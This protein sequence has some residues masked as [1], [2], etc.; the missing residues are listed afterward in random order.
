MSRLQHMWDRGTTDCFSILHAIS[1][2]RGPHHLDQR[3]L[4]LR[5]FL[6]EQDAEAWPGRMVYRTHMRK[7]RPD[8]EHSAS[9]A[10]SPT[11]ATVAGLPVAE[12]G[13]LQIWLASRA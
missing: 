10:S 11:T 3:K 5:G 7:Y 8:H 12:D 6:A 2:G 13:F 1:E 4:H 9:G